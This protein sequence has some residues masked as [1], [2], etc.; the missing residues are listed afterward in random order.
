MLSAEVFAVDT[1][2]ELIAANA[3]W[4]GF[5][6]HVRSGD[7]TTNEEE[8]QE[9]GDQLMGPY[10]SQEI[11]YALEDRAKDGFGEPGG[12]SLACA[13]PGRS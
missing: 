2:V 7:A 12:R 5:R 13:S 6:Y 1:E 8:E 9:E 10:C 11:V 4:P 3:K